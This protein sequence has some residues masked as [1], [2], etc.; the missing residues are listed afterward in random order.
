[1]LEMKNTVIDVK[2]GFNG[3]S[4]NSQSGRKNQ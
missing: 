3:S 4:D 1:M 2:N